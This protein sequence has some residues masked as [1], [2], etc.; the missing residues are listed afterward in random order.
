MF[1]VMDFWSRDRL[2]IGGFHQKGPSINCVINFS[3]HK[4]W[5]SKTPRYL[6]K[7]PQTGVKMIWSFNFDITFI[8]FWYFYLIQDIPSTWSVLKVSY[9]RKEILVSSILS[10]NELENVNFCPS[11]LRQKFFV[12]FLGELKNQ[13][14]LSILTDLYQI[15]YKFIRSKY[16]F[17]IG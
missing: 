17:S 5:K 8:K 7:L 1:A 12:R 2:Q 16:T 3:F 14:T 11:L 4:N 15:K 10:K 6:P 9:S 13:T